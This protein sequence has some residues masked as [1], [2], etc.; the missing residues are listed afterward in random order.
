MIFIKLF[1]K[2]IFIIPKVFFL[3]QL[4]IFY[5]HFICQFLKFLRTIFQFKFVSFIIYYNIRLSILCILNL[6]VCQSHIQYFFFFYIKVKVFILLLDIF[7]LIGCTFC[8]TL[9]FSSLNV[10]IYFWKMFQNLCVYRVF[11]NLCIKYQCFLLASSKVPFNIHQS[12]PMVYMLLVTILNFINV[13]VCFVYFFWGK[14]ENF[15]N[16]N[17]LAFYLI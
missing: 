15:F 16:L 11:I 7:L 2:F 14:R 6:C 4:P 9:F 13:L 10:I 5:S 1:C 8:I 17:I 3:Y 12:M